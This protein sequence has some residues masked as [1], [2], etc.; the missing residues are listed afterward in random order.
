MNG[1][2]AITWAG[3]ALAILGASF[4]VGPATATA[5]VAVSLH[6]LRAWRAA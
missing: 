1:R 3:A 6:A 4:W 2:T 5:A